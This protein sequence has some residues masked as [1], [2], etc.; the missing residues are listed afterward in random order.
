ME[1]EESEEKEDETKEQSNEGE[2]E[3]EEKAEMERIDSLPHP[4]KMTV[5]DL[6][7]E[8]EARGLSAD[9]SKNDLVTR[10]CLVLLGAPFPGTY[11]FCAPFSSSL[12]LFSCP[13]FSWSI[14]LSSFHSFVD[15]PYTPPPRNVRFFPLKVN[16]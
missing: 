10:L 16:T 13:F 1:Q 12:A 2:E 7:A 14:S 3:E 9:G 15:E 5:A 8:L 4:S 11:I 6:K